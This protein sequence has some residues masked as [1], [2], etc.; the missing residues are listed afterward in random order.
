[1]SDRE[2]IRRIVEKEKD[3]IIIASYG[4]FSTGVNIRNLH[5]IV[6]SSPTKSMIRTLQSIGRGLRLGDDKEEA[7]LYDIS[8]DLRTK[9]WTNHTMNHFAERIKI[10]TDE[11]FQYKI[12]PIEI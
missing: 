1:M 9:S 12:Y 11:Q 6:F 5:N 7:V 10:Y 2:E 4:T 3:A 8:D